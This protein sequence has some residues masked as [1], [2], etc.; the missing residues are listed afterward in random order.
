[1]CVY[2]SEYV[3]VYFYCDVIDDIPHYLITCAK[4]ADFYFA[5]STDLINYL[6]L[7]I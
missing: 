6:V 4:V 1:M 5:G 7:P 3:Y 2:M